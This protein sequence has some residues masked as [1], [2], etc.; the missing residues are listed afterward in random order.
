MEKR[1]VSEQ[2]AFG[3]SPSGPQTPFGMPIEEVVPNMLSGATEPFSIL[4][5]TSF[6]A[7]PAGEILNMP[8][9]LGAMTSPVP[10]PSFLDTAG[11]F[12]SDA[13]GGAM[14]WVGNHK[15]E[16]AVM[17]LGLLD[18][19]MQDDSVPER[20]KIEGR[21]SLQGENEPY[22]M[23]YAS[24]PAYGPSPSYFRPGSPGSRGG[25]Y[26]YYG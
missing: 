12:A 9:S 14:D 15:I 18:Y 19:I 23:K 8:E 21:G 17:G 25:Q 1:R 6:S 20:E 22:W 5:E 7:N 2:N 10:Q 4:P 3:A 13:F 26:N 24:R 16:S 11:Q